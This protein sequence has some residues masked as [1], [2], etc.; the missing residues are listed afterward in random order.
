MLKRMYKGTRKDI[1]KMLDSELVLGINQC[2]PKD[3]R[4]AGSLGEQNL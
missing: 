1:G 4:R 3:W 2:K